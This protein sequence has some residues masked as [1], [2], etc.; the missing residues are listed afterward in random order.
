QS[1]VVSVSVIHGG[2]ADNV[3]PESVALVGTTRWFDP[4]GVTLIVRRLAVVAEH[5]ARGFGCEAKV[6]HRRL[7]PATVNEPKAAGFARETAAKAGFEILSPPPSM[8]AEDFSFMLEQK[9]GCYLWLG[10][11]KSGENPMLHSPRFDF[12]DDILG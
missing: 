8:G 9:A 12:N 6:I 11:R 1:V 2:D 5:V 10:A 3:I 4:E 7:Y